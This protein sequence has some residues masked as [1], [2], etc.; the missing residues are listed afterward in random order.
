MPREPEQT[1]ILRRQDD[2]SWRAFDSRDRCVA[3]DRDIDN[4]KAKVRSWLQT[5][6]QEVRVFN[7]EPT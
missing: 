1:I 5:T 7:V 2:G 3:H 4:C 6:D